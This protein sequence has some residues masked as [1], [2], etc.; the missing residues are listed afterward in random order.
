MKRLKSLV[1]SLILLIFIS[2][3]AQETDKKVLFTINDVPFYSDEFIRVYNKNLE[4]VKDES[5]KDL[6]NYLELFIGYK[7]KI[8]KAMQMGL[9]EDKKYQ[10]ELK[11]YRNQLAKKYLTDNKVTEE[12]ILEGYNRSLKEV[13]ASHILLLLDENALPADTLRVYQKLLNLRTEIL[14]NG[15]FG[16]YAAKFSE[17]P[18]AKQNLGDLGY[19]SAFP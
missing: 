11:S 5:Q 1:T 16:D 4:L 9:Q 19:F 2:V 6:D 18:S 13:K 14:K 8:T 10:S 12:L 3:S 7:L 17:D 15:N